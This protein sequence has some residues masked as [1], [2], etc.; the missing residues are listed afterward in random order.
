MIDRVRAVNG[1]QPVLGRERERSLTV[2]QREILDELGRIFEKGFIDIT[3]ADLAARV[4]C[5]L[6]TLYGVAQS[7]N[8]LVLIVSDRSLRQIGRTAHE[9]IEEDMSGLEAVRAYL[10]AATMAVSTI[11][12]EFANDMAAVPGGAELHEAHSDYLVDVT[13]TLLDTAV[14]NGEIGP[15]DTAAVARMIAGLGRDFSRP[16]VMADLASSPKGA[17]DAMVDIVLAGLRAPSRVAPG[18][19]PANRVPHRVQSLL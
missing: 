16:G 3:M 9:A 6:R 7:R 19:R 11:T 8:E 17:A 2:R 18:P 5:S 13:H 15:V 12:Q 10:A 14:D 1:P 4:N